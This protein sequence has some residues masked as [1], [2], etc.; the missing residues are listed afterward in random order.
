MILGEIL[1]IGKGE[2]M[3]YLDWAN[4]YL[5]IVNILNN[6]ITNL[7]NRRKHTN[8]IIEK[9]II[10]NKITQ[11]CSCRDECIRTTNALKQKNQEIEDV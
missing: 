6:M 7:K 1:G 3:N 9:L 2:M 5:E 4:E 10:D 11:F 8:N